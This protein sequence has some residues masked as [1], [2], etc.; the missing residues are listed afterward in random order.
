[1]KFYILFLCLVFISCTSVTLKQDL[2]DYKPEILQL[3]N[4]IKTDPNDAQ[5]LRDLGVIL[6][7][8]DLYQRGAQYLKK[9]WSLDPDDAQTRFYYGLALEFAGDAQKAFSLYRTF[10][11]VSLLSPYRRL[12]EGRYTLLSRQMAELEA[13]QLLQAEKDITPESLSPNLIAVF[14][15]ASRSENTEYANLGRGLGEMMITD[16]SQ[17][18]KI[19]LVER[20][21]LNALME[22]MALGQTGMIRE[23]SEAGF[24]KLLG[25]GKSGHRLLRYN[26]QQYQAER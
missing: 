14:P 8:T 1:M 25:A 20:I 9:S 16:L 5:S 10:A 23:G 21:R 15:F 24:G 18:P 2:A 19:E 3:V 13:R 26:Q 11:D 7:K 4:K 22:E 12:M 17:V 6:V